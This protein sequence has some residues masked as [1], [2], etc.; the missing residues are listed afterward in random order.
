MLLFTT[1]EKLEL[2]NISRPNTFQIIFRNKVLTRGPDF[3]KNSKETALE[4]CKIHCGGD[5]LCLLVEYPNYLSLWKEYNNNEMQKTEPSQQQLSQIKLDGE[6]LSHCQQEL[7]KLIGP[8]AF[9]ICTHE[10][11]NSNLEA[12]EF[13]KA[14]S[15]QI[16]DKNRAKKFEQYL[17]ALL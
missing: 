13:I 2:Q 5:R 14:I 8:I 7:A 15:K 16:P 3:S 17:L 6:F 9:Q 10:A 12:Q 11:E 4:F 1:K